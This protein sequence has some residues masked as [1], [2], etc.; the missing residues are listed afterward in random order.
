M[1]ELKK[2]IEKQIY[3]QR[4]WFMAETAPEAYLQQALRTLHAAV[5]KHL[6]EVKDPI[7]DLYLQ[8]KH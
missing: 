6:L 5:E 7:N 3:D 8:D 1:N 4:I 2:L